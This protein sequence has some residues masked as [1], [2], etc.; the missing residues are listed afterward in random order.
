MIRQR[1]QW[2]DTIISVGM[3]YSIIKATISSLL[4]FLILAPFLLFYLKLKAYETLMLFLITYL[5][6]I[7]HLLL[8]QFI[9]IYFTGIR[10][11]GIYI[12]SIFL[13][14]SLYVGINYFIHDTVIK[15]VFV[16]LFIYLFRRMYIQRFSVR[17]AFYQDCMHEQENK[18]KLVGMFLQASTFIG[19]PGRKKNKNSKKIPLLLK[20]SNHIFKKRT[21]MNGLIEMYIKSILRNKSRFLGLL[22]ILSISIYGMVISPSWVKVFI[23]VFAILF[24]IQYLMGIWKEN[25]EVTFL[26]LFSWKNNIRRKAAQLSIFYISLPFITI[27]S[28]VIGIII[29]SP[30]FSIIMVVFGVILG[31][32]IA[33]VIS[34]H[35]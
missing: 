19:G 31:Y 24:L 13:S 27:I 30:L 28:L 22:Q 33:L 14:I 5:F 29:L 6:R 2:I 11:I 25:Q 9:S 34:I 23:W 18:L 8:K 15:T 1:K 10:K 35:A 16:I 3:R 21:P 4:V 17:W 7:I 20:K 12:I 26:D 32:F